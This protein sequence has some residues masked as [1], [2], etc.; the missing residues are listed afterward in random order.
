MPDR[1]GKYTVEKELGRG[2]F[3]GVYLASIRMWAS[4]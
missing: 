2:G 3:R 1:I 4:G